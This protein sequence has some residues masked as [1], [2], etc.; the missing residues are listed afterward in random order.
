MLFRFKQEESHDVKQF[1]CINTTSKI[2][3]CLIIGRLDEVASQAHFCSAGKY[4]RERHIE[5]L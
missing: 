3:R 4:P 1:R 2:C 5:F